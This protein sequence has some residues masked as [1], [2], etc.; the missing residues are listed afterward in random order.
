MFRRPL[1]ILGF[2]AALSCS[3]AAQEHVTIGT[4]RD[5][6]NSALFLAD[7]LGYFKAE[8]LDVSMI[9][10]KSDSDVVQALAGGGTDFGLAGFTIPAFQY[11]GRGLIKAIAV[12][13]REKNSYEGNQIVVSNAAYARGLRKPDQLVGI[14]A[15][16]G[17]IGSVFHYQ[18]A[19]VARV[20]GF[21]LDQVTL[22]PEGSPAAIGAALEGGKVD[23]AIVP[24]NYARNL[25]TT[26]QAKLVAWVSDLDE[27]QLGALFVSI[28]VLQSRRTTVEKF[29][30][31]YR[32][33][34]ADY[35]SSLMRHDNH[36]RRI[37]NT[38][39]HE[40]AGVIARYVYPGKNG[41]SAVVEADAYYL[42]S[43]ARID[44]ADLTRQIDWYRTQ[45]LIDRKFDARTMMDLSFQAGH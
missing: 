45:G 37:S 10:Y 20:K 29:L 26:N 32:R 6:H 5:V 21:S 23:A 11:A 41:G 3:A 1:L 34:A 22:K 4:M 18:F 42:D 40:A 43:D 44:A 15:A 28:K 8:G 24:S 7:D 19:Q 33:G 38:R 36:G 9:A 2:F 17:E 13:S 39:S 14:S 16:I 30:R 25:M 35:Y 12:Q 27:T 31:A